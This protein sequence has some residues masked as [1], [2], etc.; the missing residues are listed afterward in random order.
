[1]K[2]KGRKQLEMPGFL[3]CTKQALKK[4]KYKIYNIII[5]KFKKMKRKIGR[6]SHAQ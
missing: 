5:I 6:K 4:I 3:I 1:M 2:I